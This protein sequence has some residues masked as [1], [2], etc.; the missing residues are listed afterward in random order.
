MYSFAKLTSDCDACLAFLRAPG[1]NIK[2]AA[3]A[4]LVLRPDS[5]DGDVAAVAVVA[6]ELHAGVVMADAHRRA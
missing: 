2:D 5:C 4:A 3:V 1:E 6:G